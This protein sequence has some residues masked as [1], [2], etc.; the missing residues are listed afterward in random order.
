MTGIRLFASLVKR[1]HIWTISSSLAGQEI[2]G[3]SVLFCRKEPKDFY[4]SEAPLIQAMAGIYPW[5]PEAKVF[6]FFFSEKNMLAL[7]YFVRNH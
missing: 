1:S 5:A 6:W 7:T 2:R 4:F 3:K